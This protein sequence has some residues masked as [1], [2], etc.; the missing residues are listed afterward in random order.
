MLV[1]LQRYGAAAEHGD[2]GSQFHL[3]LALDA[4]QGVGQDAQEA[5]KWL[6]EAANVRGGGSSCRPLRLRSHLA[7]EY[8]C[9]STRMLALHFAL[10]DQ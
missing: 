8:L 7:L 2:L 5:A 10:R 3:A 9:F 4:G 1:P 6:M